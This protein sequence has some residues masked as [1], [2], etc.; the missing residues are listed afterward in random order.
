LTVVTAEVV[1]V[2]VAMANTLGFVTEVAV[3]VTVPPPGTA[4]GA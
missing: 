1:I 2:A 3:I 4:L